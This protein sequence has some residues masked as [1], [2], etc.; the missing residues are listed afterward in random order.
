MTD[1]DYDALCDEP[2]RWVCGACGKTS[3]SQSGW[4][5]SERVAD[6]GWDESCML[7]AILCRPAT[8]SEKLEHD[9]KWW[10]LESTYETGLDPDDEAFILCHVCGFR[11][12]SVDDIEQRFC[13]NCRLYHKR[14]P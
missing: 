11:S 12:Y 4:H 5:E 13:G 8:T 6:Y 2:N 3:R 1:K 10:Q 9:V 14:V 7:K